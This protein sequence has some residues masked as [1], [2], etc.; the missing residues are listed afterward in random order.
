MIDLHV[1]FFLSS[2][3]LCEACSWELRGNFQMGPNGLFHNQRVACR[4]LMPNEAPA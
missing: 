2:V 4:L 3:F 1:F